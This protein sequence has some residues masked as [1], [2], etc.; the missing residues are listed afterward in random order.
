MLRTIEDAD[1]D[2]HLS[3]V[4]EMA[5]GAEPTSERERSAAVS[6][7]TE[8]LRLNSEFAHYVPAEQQTPRIDLRP[9]GDPEFFPRGVEHRYTRAS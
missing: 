6:I 5:P 3:V 1:R 7:R 8:L 2:R 4:V 9:A